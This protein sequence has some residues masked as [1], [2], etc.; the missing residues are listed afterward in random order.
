MAIQRKLAYRRSPFLVFYWRGRDLIIENYC[1]GQKASV[2]PIACEVLQ[3]FDRWQ[4]ADFL[5]A[6]LT[7]F[8]P[9]SLRTAISQLVRK[10]FLEHSGKKNPRV[11]KTLAAW[12]DW[13]PAAGFFHF[14]TRDT[15]Y[16]SDLDRIDASVRSLARRQPMPRLAKNYPW[17][18]KTPL[19]PPRMQ[20]EFS[21]AFLERRTWRQFSKQPI[22]LAELGTL[23]GLAF[24]VREWISIEGG[25]K[26]PLKTSPSA[27]AMHPIE[28]YVVAQR[29]ENLDP[30]IY[31]YDSSKHELG[32]LRRGAS[33]PELTRFLVGQKWFAGAAATVFLSAVFPRAQWKYP[34]PRAYRTVLI[35]AGHFA[36]T[37]CL[38]ATSLGLAP[39][40]SMALAESRIEKAL[41]LDGVKEGVIYAAGVGQRPAGMDWETGAVPEIWLKRKKRR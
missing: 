33:A 11:R 37:F 21:S 5:S 23:L 20:N 34:F 39:F 36:Q 9:A 18:R 29:V 22:S 27:G 12:D 7:Q 41:G 35:E 26:F 40:C 1:T 15:L 17:A 28:A 30:G 14:S 31:H 32:L 10:T 2:A 19:P 8:T 6:H 4:T 16:D 13:N 38:A 25:G 3:F 24:G